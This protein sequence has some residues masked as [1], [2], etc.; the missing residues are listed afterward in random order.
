[1]P[2]VRQQIDQRAIGNRLAPQIDK[3][4]IDKIAELAEITL[5][6]LFRGHSWDNGRRKV[7]DT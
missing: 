4:A 2:R 5:A 7:C 3:R 1:M 6:V